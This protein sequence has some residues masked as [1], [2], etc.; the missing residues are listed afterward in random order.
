MRWLGIALLP[1]LFASVLDAC[2]FCQGSIQKRLTLRQE[3]AQA[4]LIVCGPLTNPRLDPDNP[5]RGGMTDLT[6]EQIVKSD[7]WLKDRKFITL[8][9]YVFVDA[10]NPP[11]YLIFCDVF[12]DKFDPY[13]GDPIKG[14]ALIPYLK[15]VI[16]LEGKGPVP[17]LKYCFQHLDSPD[18]SIAVD[19]FLEFA[20][21]SDQ[22]VSA[23]AKELQPAK[24]RKLLADPNTPI[25]R[26]GVFAFLLGACGTS[27]DAEFLS[28]MLHDG[29]ERSK[30]AFS[31]LLGGYIELQPAEG[32]KLVASILTDPKRPLSD[33]LNVLST[34][35]FFQTCKPTEVKPTILS[36]YQKVV[37]QGDLA[38]L[39]VED[40][41]RWQWWDLTDTITKSFDLRTHQSQLVRRAI[42]RYALSCPGESAK[43]FVAKVRKSDAT[44]VQEI[45][46]YLR[47]FELTN[48]TR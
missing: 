34:V 36:L 16:A 38:D 1:I 13:R 5:V 9:R 37:E 17:L 32:W 21:A 18:E 40:L 42:V 11:R 26:L 15:G 8:P 43:M 29:S 10:K 35:R 41:R 12:K 3:A 33:R 4:K 47:E 20:K 45:E 48:P 23:V 28:K 46:E 6:I 44:L 7:P 22:D 39:V 19:A 25:E 31:G 27:Q 30:T 14:D 24:L 2:S